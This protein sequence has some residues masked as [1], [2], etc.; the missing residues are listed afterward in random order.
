VRPEFMRYLA[1]NHAAELTALGISQRGIER[2]KRK[3]DPVDENGRLYDVNIDHIIERYGGG[4]VS[5]TQ[6]VD[7]QM[8][9][10]SSATY[11]ANHFS[12][13][14]L[15]PTHVHEM[16]NSLNEFQRAAN[17]PY[18]Q[19]KW[20]L[21][22]VPETGPGHA[23]YVAQPQSTLPTRQGKL[24]IQQ[25]SA[26]QIAVSTAEQIG[27][28]FDNSAG[29]DDILQ[30]ALEDMSVVLSTAFDH[31]SK[32]RNDYT[33][34]L[35]FYEGRE[36]TSL[37]EKAG[38]LPPDKT[39]ELHKTVQWIDGRIEAR[40]NHYAS[41]KSTNDNKKARAKQKKAS[42]AIDWNKQPHTSHRKKQK[43][44]KNNGR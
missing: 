43:K 13:L 3:L 8:P 38:T 18:G 17:T 35:R 39:A 21:M 40:F 28:I 4:K 23:G 12:N 41:Q 27:N 11:L 33:A 6:E 26:L 37:R 25:S 24:R 14:L 19:S 7:P 31:A 10:G 16:K 5:T 32:P 30:P 9:R 15:L 1:E 44:H 34:F 36:F 22:L 42:K 2:M 29:Q 20:I